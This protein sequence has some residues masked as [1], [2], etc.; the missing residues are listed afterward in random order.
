MSD[1]F[2]HRHSTPIPEIFHSDKEGVPFSHCKICNKELV[3]SNEVYLIEKAYGKSPGKNHHEVIF[4][5]AYCVDCLQEMHSTL[6]EESRKNIET[7]F[8]QNTKLTE[9][10]A[11]LKKHD[12]ID[13]EVWLHSCV[14]KNKSKDEVDEFQVYGLCQGNE[15]IF[16]QAPYMICG[17]AID[18]VMDLLS[19]ESLGIINDFMTD[20]IDVPP[21]FRE[22]FKTKRP[23]FI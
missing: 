12:L 1:F 19:N 11:E 17:E 7:Y 13:S 18:E 14:V 16:H 9:R 8:E 10:D 6:S 20:L 4:E 2:D 5:L 21:A 23:L 15:L 22:L 3:N